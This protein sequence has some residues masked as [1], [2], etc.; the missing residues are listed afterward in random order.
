MISTVLGEQ[1]RSLVCTGK[2]TVAFF[3]CMKLSIVASFLVFK[4]YRVTGLE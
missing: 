3:V 2:G 1:I 4:G